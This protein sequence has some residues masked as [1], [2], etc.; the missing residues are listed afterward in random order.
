MLAYHND[1]DGAIDSFDQFLGSTYA[2][3]A[4]AAC[5]LFS[6]VCP[7]SRTVETHHFRAEMSA[8]AFQLTFNHGCT[9]SSL[10]AFHYPQDNISCTYTAI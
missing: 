4:I 9:K 6:A 5:S 2:R 7:V 1:K 8:Q 10:G 3:I